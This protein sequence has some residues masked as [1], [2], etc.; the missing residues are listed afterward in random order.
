VTATQLVE[1][2]LNALAPALPDR[3]PAG[4]GADLAGVAALLVDPQSGQYSFTSYVGGVG[5]GARRGE[6]GPSALFARQASGL[7]TEP[8]EVVEARYPVLIHRIALDPD[9]GGPGEWRGG[10]GMVAEGEFQAPGV[11]MLSSCRTSGA[12]PVPSLDGGGSPSRQN[13]VVMYVGEERELGPP[14]G[15]RSQLPVNPGVRWQSWTAGGGGCGDPLERSQD[16]VAEDVANEYVS[17]ESASRDYGVV[18]D[19]SG[20]ADAAAT[21]RRRADMRDPARL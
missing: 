10:L 4:S 7:R 6:D 17:V 2:M 9:S 20:R 13:G 5:Q 19:G 12:W 18:L 1:M 15:F 21:E 8:V 14:N 16:T 3:I 11:A